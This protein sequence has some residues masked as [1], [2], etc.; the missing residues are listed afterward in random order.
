MSNPLFENSKVALGFGALV[1][2]AGLTAAI[3]FNGLSSEKG[4]A[5]PA[6]AQAPAEANA[7][8]DA[9]PGYADDAANLPDSGGG[10]ADGDEL[11]GDWG[12]ATSPVAVA[13][14]NQ[15]G[16]PGGGGD[17]ADFGD[18]APA[19]PTQ[20]GGRPKDQPGIKSGAARGAPAIRPPSGSGELKAVGN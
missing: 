11:S 4:E 20:G 7:A 14:A 9:S 17:M 18:F 19:G 8:A 15:D 6:V 1:I 5:E 16:E 10:W 12:A 3:A 2:A 13:P